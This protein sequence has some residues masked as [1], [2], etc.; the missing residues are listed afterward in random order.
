M[1]LAVRRVLDET[2]GAHSR[3]SI[4]C[5]LLRITGVRLGGFKKRMQMAESCVSTMKSARLYPMPAQIQLLH[6]AVAQRSNCVLH[7]VVPAT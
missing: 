2:V 5:S 3:L 7:S 6:H 1:L 4:T